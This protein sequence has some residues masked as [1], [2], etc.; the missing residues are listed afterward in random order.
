ME[1]IIRT[2]NLKNKSIF[3]TV[4]KFLERFSAKAVSLIVSVILARLLTPEDYSVVGIVSIFFVFANI[5]ISGGFETALIQKK[6]VDLVDYSS[7]FFLNLFI[8]FMGYVPTWGL[9]K[10]YCCRVAR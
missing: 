7:V 9:L 4:W 5:L 3:A 10:C 2:D 1:E 6:E 8:C